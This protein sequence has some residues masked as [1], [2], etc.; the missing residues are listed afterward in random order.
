MT[1]DSSGRHVHAP[2]RP[3]SVSRGSLARP[4]RPGLAA[5]A[6]LAALVALL[7]A[8]LVLGA[9]PAQAATNGSMV[10]LGD[11]VASGMHCSC[12]PFP[13]QYAAQVARGTGRSVTMHNLAFPGATSDDVVA[14]VARSSVQSAVRSAGTAL[15]MIGAN[16]FEY[17]FTGVLAHQRRAWVAFPRV[18]A[19]VQANVTS[20]V[21]T[22]QR[23][24]PGIHV[25]V[26][27]YWNVMRDGKVGLRTYGTWGESKAV[28]ATTYADQ[29]LARAATAT[30]ATLV[31]TYT[32]FKGSRGTGDPTALLASDGD[33]PNA[34][35]HAVIAAA[36]SRAARL[37]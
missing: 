3:T 15:V 6:A 11:S 23:L 35:G 20:I 25:V 7:P 32:A 1:S 34:R 28:Q 14:Q 31:S 29:G 27:D 10:T 33:H 24:H 36:F 26:A 2:V 5:L 13:Q 9:S 18:A 4:T 19:R 22:L 37:G 30:G 16:D 17:A 8:G 21:R 12:T